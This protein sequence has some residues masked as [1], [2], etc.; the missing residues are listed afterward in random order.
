MW[1]NPVSHSLGFSLIWHVI[2]TMRST[3]LCIR[4]LLFLPR[5]RPRKNAATYSKRRLYAVAPSVATLA[6]VIQCVDGCENRP[7]AS[8]SPLP[9]YGD[10]RAYSIVDERRTAS[11][12]LDTISVYLFGDGVSDNAAVTVNGTRVPRVLTAGNQALFGNSIPLQPAEILQV[13]VSTTWRSV[14]NVIGLPASRPVM[15]S[16]AAGSYLNRNEPIVVRWS[17]ITGGGVG[18]QLHRLSANGALGDTLWTTTAAAEDDSVVVPRNVLSAVNDTTLLLSLW[19]ESVGQ[20]EGFTGVFYMSAGFG[21]R[22]LVRF[23]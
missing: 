19:H 1:G 16:P 2:H 21:I 9:L 12:P 14:R 22:R 13:D 6:F 11:S 23:N 7:F 8:R 18:L 10:F 17:G 5:V 20:G 3:R 15:V 4:A